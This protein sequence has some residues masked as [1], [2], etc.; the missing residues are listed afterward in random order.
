MVRS[1]SKRSPRQMWMLLPEH[2]RPQQREHV[3]AT[4]SK[5]PCMQSGLHDLTVCLLLLVQGETTVTVPHCGM[6]KLHLNLPRC[7]AKLYIKTFCMQLVLYHHVITKHVYALVV[8]LSQG[9]L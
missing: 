8:H 1:E 4:G 3:E 5:N 7:G 6:F 9:Q 2:H